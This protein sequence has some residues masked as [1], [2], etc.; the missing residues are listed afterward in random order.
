MFIVVKKIN[1]NVI[2]YTEMNKKVDLQ[3]FFSS[4]NYYTTEFRI[5]SEITGICLMKLPSETFQNLP[6]F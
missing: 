4:K 5:T 1:N 3:S 6:Y 2:F